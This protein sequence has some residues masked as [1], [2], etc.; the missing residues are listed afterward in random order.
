MGRGRPY[1]R[2]GGLSTQRGA[3]W[4][5]RALTGGRRPGMIGARHRQTDSRCLGSSDHVASA[6]APRS[7]GGEGVCPASGS[8]YS[9]W[10]ASG[11]HATGG[12]CPCR[13]P[14]SASSRSSRSTAGPSSASTSRDRSARRGRGRSCA[15]LRSALWRLG[16]PGR[17]VV[18]ASATH[19]GLTRTVV[20][21]VHELVTAARRVLDGEVA[22]VDERLLDGELLP[23]WYED[24]LEPER[25]RL[26]QLRLHALET[27]ARRSLDEGRPGDGIVLALDALRAE[28]LRESLH[29]LVIRDTSRRGTVPTRFATTAS[30]RSGSP[31]SS[32]S[33]RSSRSSACS[34][35]RAHS[36]PAD[37]RS[38]RRRRP[39]TLRDDANAPTGPRE[40]C[41]CRPFERLPRRSGIEL[42]GT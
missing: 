28:P 5:A 21:D 33:S 11:S 8:S 31:T 40:C 9:S 30:T 10:T 35:R 15:N 27:R 26:R 13:L 39:R 23:D 1:D 37:R 7:V 20:V 19:V 42:Q 3:C 14:P 4:T 22:G 34:R 6:V 24:W 2:R 18:E 29:A 38:W 17:G 32:A 25:E 16:R 41:S 36:R 12:A